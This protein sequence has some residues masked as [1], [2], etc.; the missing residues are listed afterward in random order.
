MYIVRLRKSTEKI[1]KKVQLKTFEG[2]KCY[3]KKYPFTIIEGNKGGKNK[4]RHKENK[5]YNGLEKQTN[6]HDPTIF[7]I[8]E[9]P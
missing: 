8:Q 2:M 1:T 3:T 4:D 5:A 6:K 9:T 7:C